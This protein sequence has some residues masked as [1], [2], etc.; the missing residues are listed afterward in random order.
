MAVF[1]L[2][3]EERLKKRK[4]IDL[5][6]TSGLSFYSY[7]FK[8]FWTL[9]DSEQPYPVQVLIGVSRRAMKKAVDRNRVKR[10]IRELYRHQKITLY[11]YLAEK[12]KFALIG[13][14]YTGNSK[15]TFEEAREKINQL[16]E[17]LLKEFKKQLG[18]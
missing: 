11:D 7:P 4:Q 18:H 3:K 1:T 8:V 13:I 6:F 10:Q 12:K 16:M 2:R 9:T 15:L 14:I 17:R 5:L